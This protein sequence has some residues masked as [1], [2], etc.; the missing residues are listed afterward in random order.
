MVVGS[1]ILICIAFILSYSRAAWLSM[2]LCILFAIVI[3]FKISFNK[4]FIG[5]VILA[6]VIYYNFDSIAEVAVRN[7]S[8]SNTGNIS[9]HIE[10]FSNIQS[11]ASNAERINR[12]K[13][14]L[15]MFYDKPYMGFGPGTYQYNYGCYQVRSEMTRIST[16]HGNRGH[17]HSEYMTYLSETGLPGLV[18][19]II[20]ILYTIFIGMRV[21]Y[22]SDVAFTR[23]MATGLLL[24]LFTYFIHAVFNAFLDT[25]KM[26]MLFYSTLAVIVILD[27]SVKYEKICKIKP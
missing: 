3:Y 9:E 26:A 6:S 13:C 19:F 5:I 1:Y 20:L 2:L 4:L 10:S 25:D 8:R 12:W 15:R 14:A 21:I 17:A 22:K 11:D 23:L 7:D 27:I 24:S 16:V 18:L